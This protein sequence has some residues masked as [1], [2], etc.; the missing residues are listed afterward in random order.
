MSKF[1]TSVERFG[2]NILW[3]GYDANGKR[4]S[5]KVQFEPT[6]YCNTKD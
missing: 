1:Y 2:Q 6:L 3:R 5:K 4:F